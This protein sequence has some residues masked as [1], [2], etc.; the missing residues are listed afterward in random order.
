MLSECQPQKQRISHV[1]ISFRFSN[2]SLAICRRSLA[3]SG[4]ENIYPTEYNSVSDVDRNSLICANDVHIA[5]RCFG[6]E[7]SDA[8]NGNGRTAEPAGDDEANDVAVEIK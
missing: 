8:V 4:H 2:L 5:R 1:N 3:E 7:F 6:P